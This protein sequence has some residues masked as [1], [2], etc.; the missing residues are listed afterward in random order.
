MGRFKVNE[1]SELVDM[2]N[3][4]FDQ[5]QKLLAYYE[6]KLERARSRDMRIA[7]EQCIKQ[8]RN[9]MVDNHVEDNMDIFSLAYQMGLKDVRSMIRTYFGKLKTEEETAKDIFKQ[10]FERRKEI[11]CG[12]D[13]PSDRIIREIFD[14]L[15]VES[16]EKLVL[17]NIQKVANIFSKA[18]SILGPYV[19]LESY[20]PKEI[21]LF[22]N[23]DEKTIYL[24]L[25]RITG[26]FAL[27]EFMM[28]GLFEHL[29]ENRSWKFH[30][31]PFKSFELQRLETE[32]Y[33]ERFFDRCAAIGLLQRRTD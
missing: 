20:G 10:Y 2:R 28:K 24:Y 18:Y 30:S 22:Y 5:L 25:D 4:S 29:C 3:L 33:A 23:I 17:S 6:G 16:L 32:R 19:K 31:D 15:T 13:L 21:A 12:C 7:Y 26:S 8:I 27:L 9:F 1:H 14:L 11:Y